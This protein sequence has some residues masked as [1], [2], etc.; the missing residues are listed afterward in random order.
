MIIT[1]TNILYI[2]WEQSVIVCKEIYCLKC[3]LDKIKDEADL[4]TVS[5]FEVM[6]S[7]HIFST[8]FDFDVF[9]LEM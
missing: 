8:S 7:S 1:C 6:R 5:V 3:P 9:S 2:S 4:K